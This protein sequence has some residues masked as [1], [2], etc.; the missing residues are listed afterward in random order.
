MVDVDF[1]VDWFFV[2]M[3]MILNTWQNVGSISSGYD[4][5]SGFFDGSL[6]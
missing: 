3:T 1:F 2:P 5:P 6:I 4:N